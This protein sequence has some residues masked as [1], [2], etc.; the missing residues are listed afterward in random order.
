VGQ[1]FNV[2]SG[3]GASTWKIEQGELKSLRLLR[4]KTDKKEGADVV[5]VTV[6]LQAKEEVIGG[7]LKLLYRLQDNGWHLD[8]VVSASD[9]LIYLASPL[10]SLRTLNTA[11]ITYAATY[12]RGFSPN[13]SSLGPACS[14]PTVTCAM[15]I[16]EVLA[17]GV[18]YGYRFTYV[19]GPPVGGKINTYS[20]NADPVAPEET[21]GSHYFTDHSGVIRQESTTPAGS[22]SQPVAG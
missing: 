11:E 19:T 12:T 8:S 6:K 13:L 2:Q 3:L 18:K 20:I 16:D 1:S 10:G 5:Y 4:R 15:L 7:D 17:S 14:T 9:F 22:N 21:G